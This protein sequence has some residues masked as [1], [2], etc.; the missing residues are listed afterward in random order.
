MSLINSLK[1]FIY[2][3]YISKKNNV[4]FGGNTQI[5]KNVHFEGYNALYI[6]IQ[7]LQIQILVLLVISQITQ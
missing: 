2:Q 6:I 5:N 1:Q 3:K 7:Y 4:K